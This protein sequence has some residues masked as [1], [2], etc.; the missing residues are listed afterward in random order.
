MKSLVT[1]QQHLELRKAKGI[2]ET[3]CHNCGTKLSSNEAIEDVGILGN[4]FYWCSV[5]CQREAAGLNS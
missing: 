2:I 3:V 1:K 4:K 5:G